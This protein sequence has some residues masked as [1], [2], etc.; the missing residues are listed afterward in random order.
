MLHPRFFYARSAGG[1][2]DFVARFWMPSGRLAYNLKAAENTESVAS[3]RPMARR[4]PDFVRKTAKM[5]TVCNVLFPSC[6]HRLA[7][8]EHASWAARALLLLVKSNAL[9]RQKACSCKVKC[10]LLSGKTTHFRFKRSFLGRRSVT[11]C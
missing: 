4:I 10:M 8:V 9:G 6:L 3:F 7:L 2:V 11:E 1:F 5:G